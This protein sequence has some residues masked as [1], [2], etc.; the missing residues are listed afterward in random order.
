MLKFFI[1]IQTSEIAGRSKHF[2]LQKHVV[3]FKKT[4]QITQFKGIVQKSKSTPDKLMRQDDLLRFT[5]QNLVSRL[6]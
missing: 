6:I 4:L 3:T 1:I 2:Q 5:F